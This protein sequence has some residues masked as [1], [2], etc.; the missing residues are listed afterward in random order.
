[1]S[2]THTLRNSRRLCGQIC[3]S[4]KS[5]F[6]ASFALLDQPRRQ[7][8]VAL[9]AFARITDDLGDCLDAVE[10]RAANLAAWREALW[11][12]CGGDAHHREEPCDHQPQQSELDV[13]IWPAVGDCIRRYHIPVAWLDDLIS[14]VSM[15]LS[16]QQP[17]DWA[18]LEHYCYH[19]ASSVG[20]ACT[21]IWRLPAQPLA[22]QPHATDRCAR[23]AAIDCGI[24]FQLTNILRDVAEDARRGRIYVPQ[25]MFADYQ[26]DAELWLAGQPT[27]QWEAM[28]DDIARQARSY[29]ASGWQTFTE[30]SPH[31]QRM[32]SLMWRSYRGLL[33]RV[34]AS[35]QQLWSKNRIRL[36]NTQRLTLLTTHFIP[37]IYARLTPPQCTT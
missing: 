27:G 21:Q 31:S 33:E 10:S 8:M 20:L 13:T 28:L 23:Q 3:R 24:A 12:E 18:E 29:Y 37:S 25:Q 5:S 2:P 19:V 22:P 26:V 11:R 35:K 9:Y 32:F 7:A 15:D 36:H 16:P 17:S 1:M 34:V 4:S 14:G 30:L 6:W